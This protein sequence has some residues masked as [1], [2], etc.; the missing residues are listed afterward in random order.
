M[1]ENLRLRQ[2]QDRGPELRPSVNLLWRQM[3]GNGEHTYLVLADSNLT[4]F[5]DL[6]HLQ[7]STT[8]YQRQQFNELAEARLADPI[9]RDFSRRLMNR[10]FTSIA[11]ANLTRRIS[12]LNV[13]YGIQTDAI[14]A[15]NA[16]PH[17]FKS[18][19]AILSGPRRANPWIELFEGQLNFQ[20]RFDEDPRLAYFNNI[21][22]RPGE[23]SKY[24]V[25]WDRLG[26][27]R[28]AYLPNLDATGSILIISG[29]DLSSS[30]AGAEFITS[31]RWVQ[32][33]RSALGVPDGKPVPHFEV[34]LRAQ[35][36]PGTAP[37]FEM[38][39]HRAR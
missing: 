3:F 1:L 17:H 21:A 33:L 34:L 19:N 13:A 5:Q 31:E 24:V 4:M 10:Q 16:G 37:N 36:V 8:Q 29:T 2:R 27:C 30:D 23:D 38:I 25:N 12:L 39:A 7:L 32:Q 9:S 35:L 14:L 15:R 28:V 20:S 6:I 22:P 18:H 26:Y 11:D